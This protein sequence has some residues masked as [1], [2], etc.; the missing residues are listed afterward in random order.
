MST[1]D[2]RWF[3]RRPMLALLVINVAF[4][5]FVLLVAEIG[6]RMFITYNPGF[7]TSVRATDTE[8]HHPYGIIKINSHG[9]PDDEFELSKPRRVGYFGDSVTYG[10]GAGYPYR[11]S[12]L[13][14]AEY[15][16][17]EHLNLGGIGL[18]VSMAEIGHAQRLAQE[19][20]LT[21][22]VYLFN[23]NDILPDQAFS[24]ELQ[25]TSLKLRDHV[26]NY[27]DWLRGRSY[28]YTWLRKTAKT[29][30]AGQGVGF[31]GYS[32]YELN[33]VEHEA[34][35]AETADRINHFRD[36]MA[37]SGVELTV[38]ILPYEMQISDEAAE[39]YQAAGIEWEDGFLERGAQRVIMEHFAPDLPVIDAYW[40]FIEDPA[41]PESSRGANGLGEYFVYNKGDTLDWNHP[42]RAGHKRIA[43][44]LIREGFLDERTADARTP[45]EAAATPT[46]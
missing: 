11:V 40:A 31:H 13:L 25:P 9:Y 14:E 33:P 42:N 8:L 3:V 5:A 43:D 4:F 45:T 46:L 37:E 41:K 19:F 24:G 16:G 32:A 12:E 21:D 17:Y 6:L 36:V 39:A 23:L 34:V 15:P 22:A 27:F 10:V 7:Y 1:S 30:L 20:G 26:V 44:Y 29:I 38:V 28:V 18:S 35:L 2:P